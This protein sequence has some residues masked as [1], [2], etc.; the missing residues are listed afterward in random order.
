MTSAGIFLS[1]DFSVSTGPPF[2]MLSTCF[3]HVVSRI[4]SNK[5][6]IEKTLNWLSYIENKGNYVI[7]S[8]FFFTRFQYFRTSCYF[9]NLQH[10][11]SISTI[12][13]II[14][15]CTL[16]M[17]MLCVWG[18]LLLTSHIKCSSPCLQWLGSLE[19]L[20]ATTLQSY[21]KRSYDSKREVTQL[22]N[23]YMH[24]SPDFRRWCC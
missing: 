11:I 23:Y 20:I 8:P 14:D 10:F 12:C 2:D 19:L 5:W 16:I 7:K 6:N 18:K 17:G 15:V 9:N 22:K 4:I 3:S 21:A 1:H 24:T 13:W